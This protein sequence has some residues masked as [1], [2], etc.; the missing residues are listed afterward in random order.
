MGLIGLLQICMT[1]SVVILFLRHQRFSLVS[2]RGILVCSLKMLQDEEIILLLENI[3]RGGTSSVLGDRYVKSD[4]NKNIFYIDSITLYGWAMSESL[5]YDENNFGKNVNLEDIL[6]SPHDSD[7]GC[8]IEVDL[9]YPDEI[10]EKTKNFPIFPEIKVSP[11]D[12]FSD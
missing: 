9:R 8:F 5:A 11:Q 6:I 3:I 7:F 1:C 10:K 4:G 2:L 12:K